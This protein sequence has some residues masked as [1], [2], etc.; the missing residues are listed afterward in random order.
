MGCVTGIEKDVLLLAGPT[1]SG[2]SALAMA[3]A[4]QRPAVIV[5][6]DSMQVYTE[7]RLL[8]ARPS[9]EEEAEVPH[10]LFGHVPVTQAYS[11]GAW[12]RDVAPVLAEAKAAG[13]LAILVGGT[14]LYFRALEGGLSD[15]PEVPQAIRAAAAARRSELGAEAFHAEIMARDPAAAAAIK[16][17]DPQRSLRVWEVFEATGRP[18]SAF[19]ARAGQPLIDPARTARLVLEAP[20]EWIYA[21]IEQR[22]DAMMQAGALEEARAVFACH[23]D[24][25]LPSVKALGLPQLKAHLDG[26]LSLPEAVALAKR[27]TRRFA[28]RQMTW[29]RNQMTA[30]PRADPREVGVVDAVFAVLQ[31][32]V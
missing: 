19:Q 21:R 14:G 29:F 6:A 17:G 3:I 10:R 7:L 11:T 9:R 22:F 20:R 1:A 15:M 28:K 5:N 2:K 13:R 24:P 12:M 27:D 23:P 30:W 16:P 32:T 31:N 18:L 4:R 25:R 26:H 8:S